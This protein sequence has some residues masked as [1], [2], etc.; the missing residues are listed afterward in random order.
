MRLFL[1]R[2]KYFWMRLRT[3]EKVFL[4]I[5]LVGLLGWIPF[6]IVGLTQLGNIIQD[7]CFAVAAGAFVG[8]LIA[9]NF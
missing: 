2:I 5:W 4:V 8:R 9:E 3:Y 7:W 6:D 1:Y